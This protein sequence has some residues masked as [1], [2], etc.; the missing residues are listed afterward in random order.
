[1]EGFKRGREENKVGMRLQ[2]RGTGFQPVLCPPGKS[3]GRGKQGMRVVLGATKVG[4]ADGRMCPVSIL[5]A[6]RKSKICQRESW[7][8]PIS[9]LQTI[10]NEIA[11]MYMDLEASRLLGYRAAAMKDNG[12]DATCNLPLP[13]I[14]PRKLPS[15]RQNGSGHHGGYGG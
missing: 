4:R 12:K 7:R 5:P 13:S 11:L 8:Q 1:M 15:G 3:P 9:R 2:Y 10:Q 6:W 14:I